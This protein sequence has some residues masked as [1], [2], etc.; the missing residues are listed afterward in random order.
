MGFRDVRGHPSFR[1]QMSL[2]IS[3]LSPIV[4]MDRAR[5]AIGPLLIL[6]LAVSGCD[7]DDSFFTWT[8]SPDT[9]ALYSLSRPE[10]TLLSAFNFRQRSTV[11]IEN[12]GVGVP[13]DIALDTRSGQLVLLAPGALGVESQARVARLPGMSFDEIVEAPEDSLLYSETQ[14]VPLDLTSAYVV[15]TDLRGSPYGGTCVFYFK[16]QPLTIDVV[17]GY[18]EFVFDGSPACND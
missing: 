6:V 14:P 2:S 9:A 11:R 16:L 15:R 8:A 10:L 5:R 3:F 1:G 18:L 13:W 12:I 7:E 17:E 4:G